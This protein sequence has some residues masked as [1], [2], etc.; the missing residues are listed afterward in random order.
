M[1]QESITN[2]ANVMMIVAAFSDLYTWILVLEQ[3]PDLV[4]A[5]VLGLDLLL[6]VILLVPDIIVLFL[7]TF[8]PALSLWLPALLTP[9]E[10]RRLSNGVYFSSHTGGRFSIKALISSRVFSV[11][12]NLVITSLFRTNL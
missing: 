6:S 5:P 4:A 8:I 11:M 10:S 12:D 9:L 3:V 1:L 2:S 7:V